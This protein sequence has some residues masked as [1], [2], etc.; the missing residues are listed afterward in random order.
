[1]RL[2]RKQTKA[3]PKDSAK[4]GD[5]TPKETEP[6]QPRK[7]TEEAKTHP[8]VENLD[9]AYGH[10][11][12][13]DQGAC[14]DKNGNSIPWMTYPFLNYLEKLDL[15]GKTIFEWGSGGS[16]LYFSRR[17]ATITT[18]DSNK[19]WYDYVA[20]RTPKRVNQFLATDADYIN[21]V[22]LESHQYDIIIIDGDSD[23]RLDCTKVALKYLEA[24]GIIIFDNSDWYPESCNF[25]REQ[26]FT[27]IDFS[28]FGPINHYQWCTSLFF[29][30]R[31]AIPRLTQD[32]STSFVPGGR[33]VVRG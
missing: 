13:R 26:G 5:S 28:G 20:Q 1:M 23:T 21:A 7:A 32:E 6:S 4:T 10:S 14:V 24:E 22:G 15:T 2:F 12:T 16:T 33:E 25:L 11:E 18:V 29:K 9:S 8:I 27:Q 31:I 19:K 30:A 17:G 3:A